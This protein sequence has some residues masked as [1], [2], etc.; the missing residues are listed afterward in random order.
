MLKVIIE[1]LFPTVASSFRGDGYEKAIKHILVFKDKIYTG[2]VYLIGNEQ[3]I[4][5]STLLG[6]ESGITIITMP[7]PSKGWQEYISRGG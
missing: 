1:F 2:T 4:T 5:N 7:K 3:T 6:N